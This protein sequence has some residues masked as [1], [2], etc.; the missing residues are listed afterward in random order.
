M[1]ESDNAFPQILA[2]KTHFG[3]GRIK[4]PMPHAVCEHQNCKEKVKRKMSSL[5][6]QQSLS[7]REEQ[8][9]RPIARLELASSLNPQFYEFLAFFPSCFHCLICDGDTK[10]ASQHSSGNVMCLQHALFLTAFSE[11]G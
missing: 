8:L 7:V 10:M 11:P 9:A 6:L 3:M 2:V 1:G 5:L 4:S